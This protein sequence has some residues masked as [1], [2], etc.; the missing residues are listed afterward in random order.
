[1]LGVCACLLGQKCRYDGGDKK[2]SFIVKTLSKNFK[3]LPF[4]PEMDAFGVPRGPINI[5]FE[6]KALHVKG[7]K[8]KKDVTKK[9]NSSSDM[10]IK[11]IKKEPICGF[12]LKSKSP[13]CGLRSV[14]IYSLEDE[15]LKENSTGLFTRKLREFFPTKPM[16]E[17]TIFR[18]DRKKEEFLV[19]IFAQKDIY[20]FLANKPTF[21]GLVKFHSSYK[22]LIYS[23]SH[24]SYKSLGNIVANH[25]KKPLEDLLDEYKGG[26]LKAIAIKQSRKNIYNALLH[27]YG[28]FKKEISSKEKREFLELLEGFKKE[29]VAFLEVSKYILSY[30]KR[31]NKE[32]ILD[33]KLLNNPLQ[34]E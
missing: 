27:I 22:Y 15:V 14:K 24:S 26:F 32:Y 17:E 23:K 20:K 18:N 29:K 30:A 12:L 7:A 28:Y 4:C 8:S 19:E 33:Q 2:S 31:L 25:E 3:L 11:N 21:H 34:N 10:I 1:M 5:Y 6:K 16:T 13:S 9:I